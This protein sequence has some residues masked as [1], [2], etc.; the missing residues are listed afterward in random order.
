MYTKKILTAFTFIC[1]LPCI[2]GKVQAAAIE[3]SICIFPDSIPS[4]ITIAAENIDTV[5]ERRK[6]NTIDV[7]L[8]NGVVYSYDADKLRA[9][10]ENKPGLPVQIESVINDWRKTFTK[11]EHPAGFPGG[12][13]AWD[14]YVQKYIEENQTSLKHKGTGQIYLQFIVDT[15]GEL[16]SIEVFK[17]ENA[18]LSAVAIDALQK[19]P[20]WLPAVQ[21]GRKVVAYQKVVVKF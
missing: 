16:S 10:W 1:V 8:K 6:T 18:K 13:Q 15:D 9:Q 12:E 17:S 5:R 20:F 7:K 14:T 4:I 21:N 11:V 2:A 3:K 19:S